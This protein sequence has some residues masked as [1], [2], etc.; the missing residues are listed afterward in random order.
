[1]S[2]F[3]TIYKKEAL[4]IWRNF[5]WLWVPLVFILLAIM[6][7]ITYYFMPKLMDALGGMPE[8]MVFEFP[9]IPASDG[10]MLAL[11]QFSSIGVLIIVLLTMGTIA[12]ERKSG[13]A[14]LI[15][16]KP[17]NHITYILAKWAAK[18]S[19]FIISF[20]IGMLL[21]W[22]Y[23]NLLFGEILF[24]EIL[25]TILFYSLWILFVVSLTIFF[26]IIFKNS[27]PVAGVSIGVLI[28]T[29][30]V[31]G[32][33]SHRLNWFPNQLSPHINDMLTNGQISTELWGTAAITLAL[34]I[35][36]VTVSFFI[37]KNKKIL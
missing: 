28:V 21:N 13:I 11:T 16:V 36:L 35:I 25:Y 6:D 3:L 9:E 20:S 24:K 1:M 5:S 34:S 32:I 14:E 22:Y 7:P 10:V 17:V 27:G 37:F 4:E 26:S 33:V 31:N 29:S 19:L 15:L 12:G 23:V 18:L 8:G 2:Q 30:V